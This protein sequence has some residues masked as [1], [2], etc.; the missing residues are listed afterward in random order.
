TVSGIMVDSTTG[1]IRFYP[2]LAEGDRIYMEALYGVSLVFQLPATAPVVMVRDTS[3]T[4]PNTGLE[5][6][7]QIKANGATITGYQWS[8]LTGPNTSTITNATTAACTISGLASGTYTY[9]FTVT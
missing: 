8:Q 5:L 4:L 9:R 1:M 6:T 7:A 2:A 3:I